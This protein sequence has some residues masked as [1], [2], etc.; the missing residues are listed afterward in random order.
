MFFPIVLPSSINKDDMQYFLEFKNIQG[1][2]N[3]PRNIRI[4]NF[5]INIFGK[6]NFIDSKNL[7]FLIDSLVTE[8]KNEVESYGRIEIH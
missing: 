2:Y 7:N 3:L 4:L 5:L 1:R 8:G 6:G